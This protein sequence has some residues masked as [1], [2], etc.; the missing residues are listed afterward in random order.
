VSDRGGI[1][2]LHAA[3]P[4]LLEPLVEDDEAAVVPG[5]DLHSVPATGQED[6]KVPR[7]DVLGE[8]CADE[9]SQAVDGV[10]HVD[11]LDRHE[12][13]NGAG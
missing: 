3:E 10:P 2:R 13:A 7:E 11:G 8:L 6:E 5:E 12:D 9:R 4:A 1:T